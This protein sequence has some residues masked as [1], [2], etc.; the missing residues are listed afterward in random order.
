M[1][2]YLERQVFNKTF[3]KHFD[4]STLRIYFK[5]V[6][7]HIEKIETYTASHI[8]RISAVTK[9]YPPFN[10]YG[11]CVRNDNTYIRFSVEIVAL[12]NFNRNL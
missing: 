10:S 5:T 7:P 8:Q 9:L 12:R 4:Q 3:Q 6:L 2:I 11:L 1:T